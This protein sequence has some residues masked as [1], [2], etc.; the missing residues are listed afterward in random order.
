MELNKQ[1]T[2]GAGWSLSVRVE[3]KI[4]IAQHPSRIK[5]RRS[6]DLSCIRAPYRRWTLSSSSTRL[7]CDGWLWIARFSS[8][9]PNG[10]GCR[11]CSNLYRGFESRRASNAPL[12]YPHWTL[13]KSLR[14]EFGFKEDPSKNRKKIEKFFINWWA[15][16]PIAKGKKL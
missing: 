14:N 1:V 7:Q 4:H 13:L 15:I 9:L 8:S 12:D 5:C 10:L 16:L 6:W 3:P 2:R 11:N